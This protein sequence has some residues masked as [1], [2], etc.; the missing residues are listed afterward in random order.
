M[1]P[2]PALALALTANL[3]TFV[4]TELLETLWADPEDI[5]TY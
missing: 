5:S 3:S 2:V 1:Y 4:A